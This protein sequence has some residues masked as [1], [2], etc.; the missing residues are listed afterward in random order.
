[1]Y[2][3]ALSNK[4]LLWCSVGCLVLGSSLTGTVVWKYQANK[5]E[6][7]ILKIEN[8]LKEA[9]SAKTEEVLK[10]DRDNAKITQQLEEQAISARQ[11]RDMLLVANNDLLRKYNGLRFRGSSCQQSAGTPNSSSTGVA[12]GEASNPEC[13][14]PEAASKFI[15]ELANKA[16]AL[17]SY[18]NT[19]E[20]YV[21]KIEEQRSRMEKEQQDS[22]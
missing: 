7:R 20:A 21:N 15:I 22:K 13:S 2:I 14:L 10:K 1:M 17:Q 6:A 18:A 19:C 12:Q 11:E 9:L 16:D 3:P 8:N 4:L 5:Y